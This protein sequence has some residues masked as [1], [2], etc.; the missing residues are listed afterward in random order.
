MSDITQLLSAIETGD[1]QAASALLPVVYDELRRLARARL[2]NEKDG[3]SLQPTELVHEAYL[4]LVGRTNV[5]WNG[6]G[7]FFGAAA[8]AMRRILI[9]RARKR[10]SQKHGGDRLKVPLEEDQ[11]QQPPDNEEKLIELDQ[12]LDEFESYDA[13]KAQYVKL[14]YFAGLTNREASQAIGVSPSTGD[15]Y[16]VFCKAWLQKAMEDAK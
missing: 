2:S 16:W 6:R 13:T 8:E 11:F 9:E 7:H 12:A 4:R 14:R 5:D 15:R 3:V 10:C 1:E